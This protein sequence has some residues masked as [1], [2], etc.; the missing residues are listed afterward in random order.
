MA[1]HSS[2]GVVR[3]GGSDG[4]V[5]QRELQHHAVTVAHP[6]PIRQPES[7][8]KSFAIDFT[9]CEPDP[10]GADQRLRGTVVSRRSGPILYGWR[11]VPDPEAPVQSGLYVLSLHGDWPGCWFRYSWT[12]PDVV[13]RS[14]GQ[15]DGGPDRS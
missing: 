1:R 14:D 13:R 3:D 10:F 7:L 12:C 9:G 11:Y 8:A 4:G 15:G 5:L 6:N 2:D